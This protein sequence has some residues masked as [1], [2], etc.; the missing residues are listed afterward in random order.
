MYEY[1][2]GKLAEKNLNYVVLDIQ[3]IGYKFLVPTTL[4]SKLPSI[5]DMVLLYVSWLVRE[6]SQTLY[7]F[8]N[9]EERD[10]FE[11]LLTL[12]GIGPKTALNV[13]GHYDLKTLEQIIREGN[14][15]ALAEISGIGKKTAERL[16]LELKGKLKIPISSA[17]SCSRS[18]I[19]DALNA[20]IHLGCNYAQAEQA[21]R[22][23]TEE[24]KDD[25]DLPA[26]ITAALKQV[27]TR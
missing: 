14:S 21:V 22:K 15:R 26:L 27:S 2:Q 4:M 5:G 13:I 11:T 3:G 16:L 17:T 24:L 8:L 1:F 12:P 25:Y 6:Q 18:H 9:K 23:A 7:A 20:L 19:Q 10:L